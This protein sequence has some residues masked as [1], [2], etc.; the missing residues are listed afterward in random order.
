MRLWKPLA[1]LLFSGALVGAAVIGPKLVRDAEFA[2]TELVVDN[3]RQAL[4][5]APDL[6]AMF[7]DV[8]KVV[9]PSVVNINVRKTVKVSPDQ[10][11]FNNPELRRFF[12]EHED[13]LPNLRD[14]EQNLPHAYQQIG[15]GSGFII[16]VD[17]SRGYILTNNH[18]AGGATEMEITLSDGRVIKDAK[19]VGADPNTDLAVVEIH[20][21]HLIAAHWGDSGKLQQ[22]DRIM[23]F[24]SPFGYVGSMTH[25]IVSALHRQAGI[26]GQYGLEDFVQVDAPINP[27]NSGGPLVNTCGD[28]VGINTAIATE[29]GGFQ[30]IG[31][32]IPSNEAKQVFQALKTHGKIVRG[33]MGLQIADVSKLQ[34]QAKAFGFEGTKGVLVKGILT[35]SPSSGKLQP[36]DV[37]TA[38][39]GKPVDNSLQ[40]RETVAMTTPG[41]DITLRVFRSGKEQDVHVKLGEQ[42]GPNASSSLRHAERSGMPLGMELA[43]PTPDLLQQFGLSNTEKGALVVSVQP[44]SVAAMAGVNTGDLITKVEQKDVTN[45]KQAVD[46]LSKAD[47]KKGIRLYV[48]NRQGSEFLFLQSQQ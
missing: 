20:A 41:T 26:L 34:D 27:G 40:L 19:L 22:G 25:G 46:L 7:R 15:T 35:D 42:P 4:A 1:A 37:I 30:G 31:F 48:T 9:E 16:E 24:G 29:S 32:A 8:A 5:S 39:N 47:V 2:H 10:S 45:A 33:W 11:P 43:D 38:I 6:S 14:F 21:D 23:A 44:G 36:G 13:E 18:V 28:V 17:G 3:A 12:R